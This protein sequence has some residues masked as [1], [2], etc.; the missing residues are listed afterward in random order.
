[1]IGRQIDAAAD[2][3]GVVLYSSAYLDAEQTQEEM[4]WAVEAMARLG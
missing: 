2:W 3:D 1:M 4:A